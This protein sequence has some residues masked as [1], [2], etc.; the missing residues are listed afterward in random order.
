[1]TPSSRSRL[2]HAVNDPDL[3][4]FVGM[5]IGA[6]V[7]VIGEAIT[8]ANP[9][10]GL[11]IPSLILAYGLSIATVAFIIITISRFRRWAADADH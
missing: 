9:S 4:L 6:G 5:S 11:S 7:I 1:M 3:N 10:I 2:A 8:L